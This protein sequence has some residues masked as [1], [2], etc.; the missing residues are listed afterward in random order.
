MYSSLVTSQPDANAKTELYKLQYAKKVKICNK[1]ISKT[2]GIK[3]NI[4]KVYF[5]HE[6]KLWIKLMI[7]IILDY[8]VS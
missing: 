4:V 2:K 8:K 5:I 3:I 6:V 1:K 7:I